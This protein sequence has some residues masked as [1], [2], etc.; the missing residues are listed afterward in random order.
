MAERDALVRGTGNPQNTTAYPSTE[1]NYEVPVS[2]SRGANT[3]LNVSCD[4]SVTIGS[5]VRMNALT[6]VNALANNKSNSST[7]GIVISKN[8]TTSCNIVTGGYTGDIF[9]G[10]TP[11]RDY[12]LSD[13]SLGELTLT[14]P[15]AS[16]SYV[17]KIG[18]AQTATNFV[19]HIERIARRN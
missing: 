1:A 5:V 9:S 3:I 10:L 7:I 13:A 14:P 2:P 16:G 8:S 12:F 11:N 17:V 6:A 15:T 18:T 19:I 4:A